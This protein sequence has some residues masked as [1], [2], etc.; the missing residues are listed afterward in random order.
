MGFPELSSLVRYFAVFGVSETWLLL[1]I[2]SDDY[3]VPG[4]TMLRHDCQTAVQGVTDEETSGGVALYEGGDPLR[5]E[6]TPTDDVDW[7]RVPLC[8]S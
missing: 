6:H 3:S 4:Y 7:H 5:A 8:R 2:P 1:G